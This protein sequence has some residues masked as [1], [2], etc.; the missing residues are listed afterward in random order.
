MSQACDVMSAYFQ[1]DGDIFSRRTNNAA[2]GFLSHGSTWPGARCSIGNKLLVKLQ[3]LMPTTPFAE[4][5]PAPS[6]GS[7]PQLH[8]AADVD[9]FQ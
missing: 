4:P 7:E 9:R 3:L 5:S 6:D 2:E 1:G 8:A